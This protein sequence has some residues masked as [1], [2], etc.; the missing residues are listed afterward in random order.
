MT[1][2]S[3]CGTDPGPG[4]ALTFCAVIEE[5][6]GKIQSKT[7]ERYLFS[8][9]LSHTLGWFTIAR[10]SRCTPLSTSQV[11]NLATP[12]FLVPLQFQNPNFCFP[13]SPIPS[14]KIETLGFSSVPEIS[15][16]TMIFVASFST[17]R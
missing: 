5:R 6:A 17:E 16:I 9:S 12:H 1:T 8:L 3:I 15:E 14:R 7:F 2:Y 13:S 11:S 4:P 10:S